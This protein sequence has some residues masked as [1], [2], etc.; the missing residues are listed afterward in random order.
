MT[1]RGYMLASLAV[2]ALGIG[3]VVYLVR[4]KPEVHVSGVITA[5]DPTVTYKVSEAT[6]G[7]VGSTVQEESD[8][9][10]MIRISNEAIAADDAR[11]KF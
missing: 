6:P 4:R 11:E 5:G 8:V 7:T 3:L 1:K 9:A 10:R 2:A